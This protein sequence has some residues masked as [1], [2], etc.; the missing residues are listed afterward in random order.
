M[1]TEKNCKFIKK[2]GSFLRFFNGVTKCAKFSIKMLN[3]VMSP[4]ISL[5]LHSSCTKDNAPVQ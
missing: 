4:E 3:S 1:L 5:I 2:L